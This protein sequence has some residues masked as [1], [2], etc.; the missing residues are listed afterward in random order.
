VNRERYAVVFEAKT[1]VDTRSEYLA[2]AARLR[3][4]LD[5]IPGFVSIERSLSLDEEGALLSL[6]FWADEAALVRW[7]S[8]EEHHAAQEIGRTRIFSDYRL[9]VGT[10]V[11]ENALPPPSYNCPPYHSRQFMALAQVDEP[12]DSSALAEWLARLDRFP[13]RKAYRSIV[14]GNRYFATITLGSLV[15]S[16]ALVESDT[17]TLVKMSVRLIEVERDYGMEDRRQAPQF[18]RARA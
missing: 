13:G 16:Q 18:F 3:P 5:E 2:I 15:D 14:N 6:S 11:C 12:S 17:G 8:T 7:R 1:T 4:M 9:R 10:V